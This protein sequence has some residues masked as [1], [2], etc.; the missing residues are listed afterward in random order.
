M[1]CFFFSAAVLMSLV[2][3]VESQRATSSCN[4]LLNARAVPDKL[5]RI[6]NEEP[7]RF[8]PTDRQGRPF[9]LQHH[10][11]K[12]VTVEFW[13][14]WCGICRA[15][16]KQ[17]DSLQRRSRDDLVVVAWSD[18]PEETQPEAVQLLETMHYDFI[19]V[20]GEKS[21]RSLDI[22]F[23]PARLIIDRSGH[24][25]VMEFGYTPASARQFELQLRAILAEPVR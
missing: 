17:T 24:L 25:R 12:V 23:L 10:L 6:V 22:P 21:Q 15:T 2:V 20:F 9:D 19:L 3:A 5:V 8:R 16:M 18:D 7:G 4:D 14:T 11:G 13:A 1:K